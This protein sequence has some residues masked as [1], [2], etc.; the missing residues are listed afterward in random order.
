MDSERLHPSRF[1]VT[2]SDSNRAGYAEFDEYNAEG[3][4]EA[5]DRHSLRQLLMD[6]S[7]ADPAT[8]Y[9]VARN[10]FEILVHS[11]QVIIIKSD[12][13]F[14]IVECLLLFLSK[15]L[16]VFHFFASFFLPS[17][18]SVFQTGIE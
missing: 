18:F 6:Y 17:P 1:K 12:V 10:R 8:R 3:D 13:F 7:Q 5:F 2:S 9:S 15:L 14:V 11:A 16:F 4:L